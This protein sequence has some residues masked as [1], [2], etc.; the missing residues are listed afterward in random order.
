M[1]PKNL[2]V[3]GFVILNEKGEEILRHGVNGIIL[4]AHPDA[5]EREKLPKDKSG[6]YP[7]ISYQGGEIPV[8]FSLLNLMRNMINDWLQ[9]WALEMEKIKGQIATLPNGE[10]KNES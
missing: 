7:I 5:K 1:K 8:V 6:G 2:N 9:K 3:A 4:L 10:P